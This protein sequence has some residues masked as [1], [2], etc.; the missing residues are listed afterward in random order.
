MKKRR[1]GCLFLDSSGNRGR[2]GRNSLIEFHDGGGLE[3][4]GDPVED[5]I[6]MFLGELEEKVQQIFWAVL[7]SPTAAPHGSK[8]KIIGEREREG[9]EREGRKEVKEG[10]K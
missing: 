9:G 2:E 10:E 8:E 5:L 3:P 6:V 4:H 7:P 1:L